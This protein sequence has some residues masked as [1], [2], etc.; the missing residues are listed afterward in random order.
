MSLV[1]RVRT[2]TVT[3]KCKREKVIRSQN[4][5]KPFDGGRAYPEE[6]IRGHASLTPHAPNSASHCIQTIGD[7]APVS[8]YLISGLRVSSGDLWC[9]CDG[10]IGGAHA[11]KWRENSVKERYKLGGR[12]W[13][14]HIA[15]KTFGE[16]LYL[17]AYNLNV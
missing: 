4:K 3:L 2:H 8:L 6:G 11:L 7:G 10:M 15:M 14:N 5:K 1:P 16:L 9:V 17:H 12:V 13:R